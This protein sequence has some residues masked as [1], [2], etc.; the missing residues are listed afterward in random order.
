MLFAPHLLAL[1]TAVLPS[2]SG[3]DSADPAL[4]LPLTALLSTPAPLPF[5]ADYDLPRG[6]IGWIS[7][8]VSWVTS[9]IEAPTVVE[10]EEDGTP[11][12]IEIGTY[13]WHGEMGIGL[14]LGWIQ[15]S[16]D[17]QVTSIDVEEVDVARAMLG[18]RLADRGTSRLFTPWARLG[19][20]YRMDD[21]DTISDDG[22]GFYLGAGLD[23]NLFGGL[24]LT[25]SLT[26]MDSQ[27][28]KATDWLVTLALTYRF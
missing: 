25:P 15:S 3:G 28:F 17:A 4:P 27:S 6:P 21:G 24:A 23:W 1:L 13:S 5:Q 18:V 14:E 8:G 22:F 12:G 26:F 7:F 11:L 9:E 19:G 20:V 16:Y 2:P 10:P